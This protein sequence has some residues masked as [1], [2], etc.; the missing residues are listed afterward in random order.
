MF[1][2]LWNTVNT[3]TLSF[4]ILQFSFLTAS[5]IGMIIKHCLW[6]GREE[7]FT[8]QCHHSDM[9][10]GIWS[11]PTGKLAS[12]DKTSPYWYQSALHQNNQPF[13][14]VSLPS[15][16]LLLCVAGVP[17]NKVL[18]A[19]PWCCCCTD[20]PYHL[21][22]QRWRGNICLPCSESQCWK[23]FFLMD[24]VLM[25]SIN[26][27]LSTWGLEH[28]WK[29]SIIMLVVLSSGRVC[30]FAILFINIKANFEMW[31]SLLEIQDIH[32]VLQMPPV[33]LLLLSRL[34]FS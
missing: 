1:V 20:A 3:F 14:K 21:C 25:H 11:G 9:D 5:A 26:H 19:S 29:L 34:Q 8:P 24:S 15:A 33:I 10:S 32:W 27:R 6:G 22:S 28:F 7:I 17:L 12:S 30:T 23:G 16:I 31:N 13:R 4:P 18:S 2:V